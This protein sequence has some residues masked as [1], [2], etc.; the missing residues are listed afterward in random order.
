MFDFMDSPVEMTTF[1]KYILVNGLKLVNL[2]IDGEVSR[3]GIATEEL[4]YYP[5]VFRFY[6]KSDNDLKKRTFEQ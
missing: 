6:P 2:Q 4:E 1:A 5:Y 3:K